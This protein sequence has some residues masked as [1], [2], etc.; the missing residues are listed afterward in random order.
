[1]NLSLVYIG[2]K[3]V[4]LIWRIIFMLKE[5][6]IGKNAVLRAWRILWTSLFIVKTELVVR[7]L[8]VNYPKGSSR[9]GQRNTVVLALLLVRNDGPILIDQPEDDIDSDFIYRYLVPVLRNRKDHR[10]IILISHNPN[11][12]VNGDADLV[13]AL[14]FSGG[15]GRLRARGGMDVQTVHDA[16]L[17]IMEG[18]EDAFRKRREKYGF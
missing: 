6:P 11:I 17:D 14:E 13:Y 15:K 3:T 2:M 9:D 10:Q 4:V 5:P 16:V 8:Q 7:K 12:V 18:S 1:M